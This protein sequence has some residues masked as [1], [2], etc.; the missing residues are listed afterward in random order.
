MDKRNDSCYL[1]IIIR[2]R[3]YTKLSQ[4]PGHVI[5]RYSTTVIPI[6]PNGLLY[7]IWK[8][9]VFFFFS[10]MGIRSWAYI[11]YYALSRFVI[12]PTRFAGSNGN[13]MRWQLTQMAPI[14]FCDV[15]HHVIALYRP[16]KATMHT[17]PMENAGQ[18]HS[19]LPHIMAV[20][21]F[22]RNL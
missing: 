4:N 15:T 6:V 17:Y 9:R 21:K 11:I 10:R 13:I 12:T 19:K 5:K 2:T 16:A 14:L 18:C 1:V 7:L 3:C 22:C 20:L 8:V